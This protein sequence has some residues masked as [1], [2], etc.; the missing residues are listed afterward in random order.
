MNF[1][2]IKLA[3]R[4]IKTQKFYSLI[5]V[6]GLTVGIT[7]FAL[8]ALWVNTE[9]SYDNFQDDAANIYRMTGAVGTSADCTG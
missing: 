4:G 2:N 5:N 1:S 8:I 3:I 9:M 7:A 6:L